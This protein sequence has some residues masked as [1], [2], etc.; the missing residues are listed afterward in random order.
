[1]FV[2]ETRADARRFAETGLRVQAA[3]FAAKGHRP[4][5]ETLDDLIR[6]FDVHLG[7]PDD[8]IA[9]L[10]ADNTLNRVTDLA[11][12]VHSVDPP[13]PWI[14]RSIELMARYVGPAFGWLPDRI[15]HA[16]AAE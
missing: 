11:V 16:Q 4:T 9:S 5:G 6:T 7:T 3:R 1:M 15:P 13:H 14:L 8:V 12:Q 2:A 10:K